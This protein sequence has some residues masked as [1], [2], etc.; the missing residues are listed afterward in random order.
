MPYNMG[1][2]AAVKNGI[3]RASGEFVLIIDADGQHPPEDAL[4]LAAQA[5]RV[6]PGD[7]RALGRD[8]GDARAARRQRRLEQPGQLPDGP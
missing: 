2:G 5:R 3:R 8:A 7:R 4:R 6:R 1:N